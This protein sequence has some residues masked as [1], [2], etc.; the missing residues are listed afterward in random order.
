MDKKAGVNR[1]DVAGNY[2]PVVDYSPSPAYSAE[3]IAYFDAVV[4]AGGVLSA[5]QK[6]AFNRLQQ[7]LDEADYWR[8]FIRLTPGMGG[9]EAAAGVNAA[10]PGTYTTTFVNGPTVG[11]TIGITYN[12]TTHYSTFELSANALTNYNWQLGLWFIDK[13]AA[14]GTTKRAIAQHSNGTNSIVLDAN[15]SANVGRVQGQVSALNTSLAYDHYLSGGR[16]TN[17]LLYIV[18]DQGTAT[19]SGTDTGG[20]PG[21][22]LYDMAE[23]GASLFCDGR[24]CLMFVAAD[25]S[26]ADLAAI[27]DYFATFIADLGF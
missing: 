16:A 17:S 4:S 9:T 11:E 10:A 18:T 14:T 26:A 23:D 8:K 25:L 13:P 15:T 20:R 5:V 27:G 22:L 1:Y 7:S 3:S 2:S 24:I 21:A 19:N 12:G 6:T